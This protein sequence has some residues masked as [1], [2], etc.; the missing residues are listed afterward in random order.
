MASFSELFRSTEEQLTPVEATITGESVCADEVGV[1]PCINKHP[2][3]KRS[4]G[5]TPYTPNLTIE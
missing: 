2:G 3:M 1:A 4:E 5:T